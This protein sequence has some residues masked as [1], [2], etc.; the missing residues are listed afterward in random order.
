[1]LII[2]RNQKDFERACQS[3]AEGWPLD[4]EIK[5]HVEVRSEAQHNGYWAAMDDD[6]DM[7]WEAVNRAA[8][9]TGYSNFEFKELVVKE[10]HLS[11]IQA[12]ILYQVNSQGVHAVLKKAK[13]IA[14]SMKLSKK[15]HSDLRTMMEAEIVGLIAEVNA[16]AAQATE[17]AA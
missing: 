5:P 6:L 14:T 4:V 10:R 11:P 1:V 12:E 2:V 7:M 3:L 16:Y 17:S 15:A 9:H 8:D 13:G